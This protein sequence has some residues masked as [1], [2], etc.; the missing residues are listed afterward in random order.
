M[1]ARRALFADLDRVLAAHHDAQ[2]D[3][4]AGGALWRACLLAAMAPA[5]LDDYVAP[6]RHL[7]EDLTHAYRR[8]HP[9]A[10]PPFSVAALRAIVR[11]WREQE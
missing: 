5:V 9:D 6:A 11:A 2:G 8:A 3:P 1:S 7:W 4:I 10:A